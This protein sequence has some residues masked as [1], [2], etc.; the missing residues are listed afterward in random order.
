[1]YSQFTS[2]LTRQF[3]NARVSAISKR[4]EAMQRV[5]LAVKKAQQLD[6]PI[7]G[8]TLYI[9][10]TVLKSLS[11]VFSQYLYTQNDYPDNPERTL[12]AY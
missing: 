10:Y 9:I 3:T 12:S 7:F 6:Q 11:Y 8:T 4:P 5:S 1:M 2:Q